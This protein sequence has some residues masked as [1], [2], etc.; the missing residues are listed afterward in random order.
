MRVIEIQKNRLYRVSNKDVWIKN[1]E[2]Q[3]PTNIHN[4]LTPTE[5]Q[6]IEIEIF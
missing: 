5:R 6:A 1:G 4:T 2:I 3:I